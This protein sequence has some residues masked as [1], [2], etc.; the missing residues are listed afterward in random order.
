MIFPPGDILH[1]L[2]IFFSLQDGGRWGWSRG[3]DGREIGEVEEVGGRGGKI[4]CSEK[5]VTCYWHLVG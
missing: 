2:E 1:F 4:R 5:L 3:G